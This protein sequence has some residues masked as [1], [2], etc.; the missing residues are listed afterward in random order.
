MM[1]VVLTQQP[2][3]F[4]IPRARADGSLAMLATQH[5]SLVQ[6]GDNGGTDGY[7]KPQTKRSDGISPLSL[8]SVLRFSKQLQC[9]SYTN[10]C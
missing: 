1:L 7:R 6:L 4:G 9:N 2:F 3:E 10:R 5:V 8:D